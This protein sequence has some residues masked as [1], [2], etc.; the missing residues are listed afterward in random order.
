MAMPFIM[1]FS[2]LVFSA[3]ADANG[4]LSLA[5]NE[6]NEQS[7]SQAGTG[8]HA[9]WAGL[10]HMQMAAMTA[11]QNLP[12]AVAALVSGDE[13]HL[14]AGYGFADMDT[15]EE[16][17]PTRHL[18]R[19][20]SVA[21]IFTWTALMQLYEK[22][23]LDLDDDIARH[24][25]SDV[26]YPVRFRGD[27]EP[28]TFRHLMTH[29]AGFEDVLEDLFMFEPQAPLG[30]YIRRHRPA[31]IFP[32]GKVMAY[33][34]YGTALAGYIV[35]RIAEMPFEAY[36]TRHIFEPLGMDNSTMEQPPHGELADRLVTPYR[37][38]DGRFLPGRFEHMPSPAG[39]LSITAADMARFLQASLRGG[40]LAGNRTA[41]DARV[42]DVENDDNEPY[43][44]YAQKGRFLGEETLALMHTPLFTHHPL[45]G[46]M[47]YGYK[48]FRVNGYQIVF[49][50]G[51]S[52]V[53]D[54]GF[55]LIPELDLGIFIAYSGGSYSGHRQ[56]LRALL[57]NFIP[58]WD[59]DEGLQLLRDTV[60]PVSGAPGVSGLTGEFLQSR[61]IATGSDRLLN[62]IMGTLFVFPVD[63]ERFSATILGQD[64]V[65]EELAP[66][67]Y[68][69]MQDTG[70][71]PFGP[72]RFLVAGKAPDGRLMLAADGPMT[73]I[74]APWYGGSA[75]AL[76]IFA[77][78]LLLAAGTLL[79]LF[80]AFLVRKFRG[81]SDEADDGADVRPENDAGIGGSDD[82]A[83]SAIPAHKDLLSWH[84]LLTGNAL[85]VA[86]AAVLL[87]TVF[88]V[89]LYGQPHPVHLLPESA[90]TGRSWVDAVLD[91]LPLVITLL[92][93]GV[94]WTA[95]HSWV[96]RH[97]RLAARIFYS[98]Y[99][100][101]T[102]GLAWF[103][104]YYGM[105][106]L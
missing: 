37:W 20:G 82:P 94:V 79:L 33:S 44:N 3:D 60:P 103:F 101:W 70:V 6:A 38:V 49:H 62:L 97:R 53:F 19:T 40:A 89:I 14:L 7:L 66:G 64:F 86:H 90:F 10:M 56:I 92:G 4:M 25:P 24:L 88:L 73:Y 81:R 93:L 15:E 95:I 77:P 85:L 76:A 67:I 18:F 57:E 58:S 83:V 61:T 29:T 71:Y 102:L 41:D 22:G 28:I 8:T 78:M 34:N 52:S 99:A 96:K 59:E 39:G 106:G 100:V 43:S 91:L 74:R 30:E 5:E 31:R 16:V 98:L 54:A 55:Y 42:Y 32:A 47:A 27:V 63:E 80:A 2:G 84:T 46:G 87:I 48:E 50:G 17:D 11:E 68:R 45:L 21:K 1:V 105:L 35:E 12:N 104:Y 36:V 72:L 13:I 75:M 9:E 65:F 26:T 51:S 69:N 23:L